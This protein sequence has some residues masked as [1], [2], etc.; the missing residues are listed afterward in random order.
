MVPTGSAEVVRTAVPVASRFTTMMLDPTVKVTAPD[1]VPPVPL[2]VAVKVIVSPI[3]DGFADELR[4]VVV[5]T[6][7]AALTTW[8]SVPE[9]AAKLLSPL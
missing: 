9:L 4:L 2:T 8:V 7:C 1:G 6:F 5:G 3:V